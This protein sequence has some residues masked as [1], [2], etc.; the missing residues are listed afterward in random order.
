MPSDEHLQN[1]AEQFTKFWADFMSRTGTPTESSNG[2]GPSPAFSPTAKQ[3]QRIFFDAMAQYADEFM[4]S[5]QFL[6]M[7]KQSMDQS[8]K[9][10]QLIDEFLTGAHRSMQSPV[11]KDID[12][13][14]SLLRGIEERIFERLGRLEE[15]VAAVEEVQ[16][17]GRSAG[18]SRAKRPS[19]RAAAKKKKRSSR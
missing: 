3:M 19:A 13:I 4:R 8:L 14:A 15:K 1:P 12:D 16:R 2:S 5:E 7:M 17:S 10:K 6:A 11:Q 9:F 18:A